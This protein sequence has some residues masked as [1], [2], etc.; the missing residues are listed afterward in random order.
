MLDL[1]TTM[2][3]ND[4]DPCQKRDQQGTVKAKNKDVTKE[5]SVNM[6]AAQKGQNCLFVCL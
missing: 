1:G 4:D 3:R 6:E 2:T 5:W